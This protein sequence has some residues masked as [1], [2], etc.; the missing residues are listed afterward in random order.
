LIIKYIKI[1]FVFILILTSIDSFSQSEGDLDIEPLSKY[2]VKTNFRIPFT[3]SNIFLKDVSDGVVD[4]QG[5]FNFSFIKNVYVG[6]GYRYAYFKLSERKLNSNATEQFK[7]KIEQKGFY[8][9]LSYFY[10]LYENFSIEANFQVGME[11]TLGNSVLCIAN[12]SKTSEKGIFY[13]PNL[14]F[15]LKTEEI[16]SFI[17]S[18][19]YNFSNTNFTPGTVCADSFVNFEDQDYYGNY[20]HLNVGFGIGISIIKPKP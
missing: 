20:Q 9:E 13:S 6:V 10:D 16:F 14:N 18:I 2:L 5:S 1:W 3:T 12:G 11:N 4:L 19:G 8:G 17:F 15:Y 7:G